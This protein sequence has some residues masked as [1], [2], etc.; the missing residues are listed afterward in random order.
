MQSKTASTRHPNEKR[1][2]IRAAR[3]FSVL[4]ALTVATTTLSGPASADA[5]TTAHNPQGVL[6]VQ[7]SGHRI[8]FYGSATDIDAPHG[9]KVA[10][11]L[12]GTLRGTQQTTKS[13]FSRTWIQP[14]GTYQLKVVALNVGA[15]TGNTLLGSRTIK[16][17]NP[18][19]RNPHGNAKI[20]HGKRSVYIRGIAYDPDKTVY[21]LLVRAFTN[22]HK[23]TVVRTHS[24]SH[25]YVAR[26]LLRPG[27]N[28]VTVIAYNIGAGNANKVIGRATIRVAT[29]PA[30]IN[31]YHGN[32]RIAAQLLAKHGW[33]AG[34]MSPLV[35][36]WNRESGWNTHAAN[37]SGAYGIP[38]ALPG[39]KMSSAGPNWQS[40]ASTQIAW[41]LNYIAGTYGS[42]SAAW[43]HSQSNGWY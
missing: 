4:A 34:Q 8:H 14:Y 39:S 10:Y 35:A 5:A 3:I 20:A 30:W 29:G 41:G 33:G 2:R 7:T 15:G 17:I 9:I 11:Y 13:R 21:P 12:N 27:V 19:T 1:S 40:S 37:P 43:A 6:G 16:L 24:R 38:Q 42:P 23:I 28:H 36:L 22:G 32:Q 18:A 26:G 25:L 31:R